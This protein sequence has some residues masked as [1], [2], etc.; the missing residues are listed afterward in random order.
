MARRF[1]SCA[2]SVVLA[3]VGFAAAGCTND[4]TY[5]LSW[6]FAG[7]GETSALT[8]ARRGVFSIRVTG[9]SM[10]GDHQDIE[11]PCAPGMVTRQV[12][13]GTWSFTVLGLDREGC[14]RGNELEVDAGRGADG[15]VI[16]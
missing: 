11:V 15:A 12:P 10:Q 1:H 6:T 2:I 16:G 4:G 8:C 3:A 9:A 5:K 7:D 14:Y 13:V